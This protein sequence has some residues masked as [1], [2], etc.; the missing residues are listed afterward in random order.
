ML[1]SCVASPLLEGSQDF[2]VWKNEFEDNLLRGTAVQPLFH[3]SQETVTNIMK[4]LN[5]RLMFAEAENLLLKS[6]LA[7]E[8][9][10]HNCVLRAHTQLRDL[11]VLQLPSPQA[12]ESSSKDASMHGG[13][14]TESP[15]DGPDWRSDGWWWTEPTSWQEESGYGWCNVCKKKTYVHSS[16][17]LRTETFKRCQ[18][19]ECDSN[20]QYWK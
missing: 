6:E 3:N 18:N 1:T 10:A 13:D 11:A 16:S 7:E 14:T 8:K 17:H 20:K 4:V 2:N 19:R 9:I 15:S 5:E 12:E